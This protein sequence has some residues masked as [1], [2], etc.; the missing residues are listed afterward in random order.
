[1]A[2]KRKAVKKIKRSAGK[3]PRSI[4]YG[5]ILN[6]IPSPK[7][8]ND[9]QFE[10]ALTAGLS[11]AA[12]PPPAKD[13]RTNWWTIGDQL[14]TG[15]CVGWACADSVIRWHL[16]KAG[17]LA[18]SDTARLSTRFPWM[19]AKETDEWPTPPTTFIEAE[20]TSL[21]AALDVARN[22][23]AVED[24]IL[25]FG[26]GQLYKGEAKTFFAIAAQFKIG[27]YFNLKRDPK[28][29]RQWIASNGPIL[30][31][32]DVDSTWYDASETKG[33]LSVYR[34]P[35]QPAGHAVALVG[36]TP[37]S[38]IVRNSWGTGWGDKG[39]AY[40]SNSYAAAAFTEAYGIVMN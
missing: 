25:P 24:K 33:D 26:S 17:K 38:F 10:N 34:Q 32:L 9:W 22:Y 40:A 29:W 13:L 39:Y 35:S 4:A 15:S 6:C 21:K 30:T 18:A 37:T 5:R 23:G 36:Y 1:M 12:A 16:V 28:R 2:T 7:P 19:A 8:E 31:R 14:D 11:S 27:S 3:R 20:G